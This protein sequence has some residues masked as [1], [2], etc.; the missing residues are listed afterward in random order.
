M[1]AQNQEIVYTDVVKLFASVLGQCR[2]YSDK[3]PAAQQTAKNF[4]IRLGSVLD[5]EPNFTFGFADG[6]LIV[7]DHPVHSK[8]PSVT[9]LL[10]ELNRLHIES[11]GFVQGVDEGEISSFFRLMVAPAKVIE[12]TGGFKRAFE[13]AKF[14][15]IRL[16]TARYQKV[17]EDATVVQESPELTSKIERM[18]EVIEHCLRGT[19]GEVSFDAERLGYEVEKKS[20]SVAGQ[21]VHRPENLEALQRIVE[22]MARFL[23]RRLAQPLVQQGKDFSQ[24]IYRLAKDLKKAL[25]L[26]E[27]PDDFKDST[28][29]LVST[30][31]RCADAVKLELITKAFQDG[32]GDMK[33]LARIAAKFLR[34]KEARERLL[35][36]LK[37]RLANL[38][39][40]QKELELAIAEKEM[41]ASRVEQK[42]VALEPEKG[43]ALHDISLALSSTLELDAVV[44][45]LLEKSSLLLQHPAATT[46]TLINDETG[47]LE[48]LA[49]RNL[50]EE[51][52][53][54][55]E[56]K[57]ALELSK[58]A[59]D[60][61]TPLVIDD[62]Q[63]D[64]RIKDREFFRRNEL[65]SYLGIPLMAKVQV[66]VLD[67]YTKEERRFSEGE[68]GALS[69]MADQA[70]TAI[71]NARTHSEV[72]K[73]ADEL[74]KSNKAKDEFL[75]VMSH[76]LRTPLSAITGY[77]GLVKERMLGE[78]N[79]QQ[80]ETLGKVMSR[81]K[82]LLNMINS[83]LE[84]THLKAEKP[85][86]RIDE[87]HLVDFLNEVRSDYTASLEKKLTLIWDFPSDLPTMKTDSEKLKHILR[88]LV[89]NAI[90]FTDE[91]QVAISA[92]YLPETRK[93]ELKV[94]DTGIGIPRESLP[95]I[96]ERFRQLDGSKTR[97]YD[98]VG[99]GLYI[100]KMFT[101][102]LGGEVGVESEPGRG[103]TFTVTLPSENC[104]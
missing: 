3:H 17:K 90:K 86:V 88:N 84:V 10:R 81:S 87:L 13:D 73:L 24:P 89:N 83:I 26:P 11:L 68:I 92:R 8:T 16:D 48:P 2:L 98:G 25:Q 31:E 102:L 7:N 53:K 70:A 71:K 63:T 28:E 76:E 60:T 94:A 37:E 51:A 41:R 74:A 44:D 61:G 67:I 72:K 79:Q 1:D 75:S 101:E 12:Q 65:I 49:C 54:S 57:A 43:Q 29:K 64:P 21:M 45:V 58:L 4:L 69:M 77:T 47:Q 55:E 91:G 6:R 14:E 52:W 78:I 23:E 97:S 39:I 35:G 85:K 22:G 5:S 46:V 34:G 103:S 9:N 19:E 95:I 96:F 56:W 36:P 27:V 82:D 15:H 104:H 93:V 99:L 38:G 100:V 18:E 59:I 66:G 32:G 80:D 50:N 40:E 42:A 62:I 20:D 30:L 33:A